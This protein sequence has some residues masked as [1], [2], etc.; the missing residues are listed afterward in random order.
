MDSTYYLMYMLPFNMRLRFFYMV[1]RD[2]FG[3]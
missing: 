3:G 2:M 1:S